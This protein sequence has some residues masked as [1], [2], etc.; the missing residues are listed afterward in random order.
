MN[1]AL[2]GLTRILSTRDTYTSSPLVG[3]QSYSGLKVL[4]KEFWA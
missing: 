2:D 3:D 1:R 4:T